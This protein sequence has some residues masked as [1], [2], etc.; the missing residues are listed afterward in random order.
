MQLESPAFDDGE[1]IPAK[2]TCDGEDI[3]PPLNWSN[4]PPGTQSLA[5][6]VDDPDAPDPKAPKRT[7]VHWV[8]YG[9]PPDTSGLAEGASEL[10][11]GAR[12]GLNDWDKPEYGG[13]CPSIGEHRYFHKLY[14]L[15]AEF[16]DLHE[17]TKAEL[18]DAMTGHILAETQ[19]VGTYEKRR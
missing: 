19:L 11:I 16:G 6:I 1:P 4:V 14:A 3:S 15:D 2:Y 12:E 10:P 18:E 5:L 7:W 9:I 17:L 13:P 8:V